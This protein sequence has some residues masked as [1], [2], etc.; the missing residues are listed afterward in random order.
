VVSE[1]IAEIADH[2]NRVKANK[3]KTVIRIRTA[4]KA[5]KVAIGKKVA[6]TAVAAAVVDAMAAM[7]DLRAMIVTTQ[8][9]TRTNPSA[10]TLSRSR[11]T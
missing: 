7:K 2:V 9:E 5:N 11:V 6:A 8:V 3:T 4:N 10:W 1:T